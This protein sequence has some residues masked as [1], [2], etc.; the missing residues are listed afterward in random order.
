M[1]QK[2]YAIFFCGKWHLSSAVVYEQEAHESL[3]IIERMIGFSCCFCNYFNGENMFY[4]PSIVVLV[5][6][7]KK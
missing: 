7:D 3:P 5:L 6:F 2:Q 1:E 4:K